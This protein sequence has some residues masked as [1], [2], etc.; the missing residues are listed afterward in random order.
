MAHWIC[1]ACGNEVH[2][3]GDDYPTPLP[4][5]DGHRCRSIRLD[6]LTPEK[7]KETLKQIDETRI[8]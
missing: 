2:T 8:L 7:Q 4:W 6:K 1:T 5:S 3:R